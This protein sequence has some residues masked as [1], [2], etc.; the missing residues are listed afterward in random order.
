MSRPSFLA[1]TSAARL[2]ILITPEGLLLSP[3]Y[4]GAASS[5]AEALLSPPS[6]AQPRVL[7]FWMNG[8]VTRDGITQDLEAMARIGVGGVLN[9]DAGT[10]IPQGPVVYL[11]PEWLELKAHAAR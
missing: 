1:R 11:G 2:A 10:L 9:F 8:N 4:A 3:A 7:W 5:C 6:A